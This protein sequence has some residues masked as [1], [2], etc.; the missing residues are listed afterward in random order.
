MSLDP[1]ILSRLQ[2]VWV[3]AWHII[4]PALTVGLASFIAF[5]EGL[6][7][8]T[9]RGIYL[10]ISTF[11]IRVFSVTFGMGV[12]SGIV[13]PFQIGMNWSRYAD[14]TANIIS[15]MLA[16]EGLTAFFL[17]AA[18]LGVLLFGRKLVPPWAHFIAA[19]MVAL[20]TLLSTFWILSV[21]SWMQTP[22]GYKIVDGRFMPRDWWAIVFNPSFPT[23]LGHTVVGFY[24]TTGFVVLSVAGFYLRRNRFIPEARLMLSITL[25]LL[26]ALVPIQIVLGDASG[27]VA[28]HY[29]PTKLA[30]IEA[31]WDTGSRIPLTLFAIPDEKH[32]TNHDAIEVPVLGSLIL[33]HN[34]NGTVRGLKDF[35]RKDWPMVILPFFAFRIMVGVGLLMLGIV[36]AGNV[37][38]RHGS[39]FIN[40]LFLLVCQWGAPLG[41]IAVLAGWTTTETGRQPWTVYGLLRTADSVSPSLTGW[42][43]AVSLAGYFLVYTVIYPGGWLVVSRIIRSG[44]SVDETPR[45]AVQS[46]RPSSP[47]RP[48]PAE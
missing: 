4:L 1:L 27:L 21:N 46:G 42:N 19:M 11:W 43:V 25:W 41:F 32:A 29:Q 30:G 24:I 26:L 6:S 12:V 14:A 34:A 31:R 13:M 23:R 22:A 2:F 9:G 48:V 3:V 15:P 10:R 18:F 47:V 16:Y 35:P 45:E 36:V 20:G 5:M 8:F 7:F 33:T 39:V 44:P 37:L 17:E 38:R 40:P 28:L